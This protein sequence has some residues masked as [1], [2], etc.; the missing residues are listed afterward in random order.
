MIKK[1]QLFKVDFPFARDCFACSASNP[2]GL[3]MQFFTDGQKFYNWH[4]VKNEHSGWGKIKHGGIAATILDELG[5]WCVI[6]LRQ[7][8]CLT[9]NFAI[10]YHKPIITQQTVLSSAEIFAGSSKKN[11][12]VIGKMYNEAN[13]LCV[14][15]NGQYRFLPIPLALKLKIISVELAAAMEKFFKNTNFKQ[16]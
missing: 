3:K 4:Y 7:G 15:F 8:M 5:G 1:D 9:Q 14:S 13:E 10:D 6:C 12:M 16:I 11:I 2:I